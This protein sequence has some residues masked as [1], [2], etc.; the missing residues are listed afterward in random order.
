[1]LSAE[2]IKIVKNYNELFNLVLKY[3]EN[4]F[5]ISVI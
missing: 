5:T 3:L 1:M 4:S 2:V